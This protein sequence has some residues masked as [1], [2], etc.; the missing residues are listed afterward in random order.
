[1]N[2]PKCKDIGLRKKGYD[3]PYNCNKCGGM[4]LEFDKLPKFFEK[5]SNEIQAEISENL[6][7]DKAGFCPSGHGLLTRAQVEDIN[8]PFYLEKCSTC[9]GIWFDNDGWLRILTLNLSGSINEIWCSSWQTQQRKKKSRKSFLQANQ[10]LF[11]SEL[12]EKIIELSELLE[13]HPEKGRAIALLQQ[14]IK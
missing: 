9:G 8:D 6:N 4:W 11:G 5:M 3:S 10:R 7:A 2:C 14:E 13:D 1:M 12:F